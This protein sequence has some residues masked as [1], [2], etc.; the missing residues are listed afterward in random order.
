MA[1]KMTAPTARKLNQYF[2]DWLG[3]QA[4]SERNLIHLIESGLPLKVIPRLI[5]RGLS[6][7]EVF[8][9]IVNPRTLKHR[10][11]KSQPLSKEESERAIR[12]VRILA[13]AQAV[14]GDEA[15]AL[16]WLRAP[17]E[18]FEGRAPMQMLSTEPGGRLVEEMLIQIDEG[19]FA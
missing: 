5:Q 11:S 1:T 7:D 13:R 12:A 9:I 18:R 8:S 6:K 4:G 3:A 2:D 17:K 16:R 19:M 14:F 10:R 15:S